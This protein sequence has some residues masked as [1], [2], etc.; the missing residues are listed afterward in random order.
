[1]DTRELDR[2][3]AELKARL[4]KLPPEDRERALDG[5]AQVLTLLELPRKKDDA[6]SL[7]ISLDG[8]SNIEYPSG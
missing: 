5:F 6:V 7:L 3:W 2:Q 8:P 4:A 1:M